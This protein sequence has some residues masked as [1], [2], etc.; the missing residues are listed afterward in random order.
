MLLFT[1]FRRFIPKWIVFS[2]CP[3]TPSKKSA[4]HQLRFI[5]LTSFISAAF[6]FG[7]SATASPPTHYVVQ[8]W[9]TS[10]IFSGTTPD[11]SVQE[12]IAYYNSI[13]IW[14]IQTTGSCQLVIIPYTQPYQCPASLF[15]TETGYPE[16]ITIPVSP[17]CGSSYTASWNGAELYCPPIPECDGP[18]Q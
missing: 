9:I 14:R 17:R 8:H 3:L 13:S 16:P 1:Y 15:R 4:W 7:S 18:A 12:Y 10:P 2:C 6:T 5:V 11:S